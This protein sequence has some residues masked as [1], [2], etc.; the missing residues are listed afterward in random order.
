MFR[1]GRCVA[2]LLACALLPHAG[3][4]DKKDDKKIEEFVKESQTR[5][6]VYLSFALDHKISKYVT[7]NRT[8]PSGHH[9]PVWHTTSLTIHIIAGLALYGVARRAF[10]AKRQE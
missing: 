4:Q 6:L 9:Y 7:S 5:M 1:A 3:A 10:R 8:K 2:I